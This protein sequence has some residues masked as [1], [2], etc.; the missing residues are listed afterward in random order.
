[1][2]GCNKVPKK[3]TSTPLYRE[4]IH[5]YEI[6]APHSEK[7][8]AV[9]FLFQ[10]ISAKYSNFN[11]GETEALNLLADSLKNAG[12][13][14]TLD[15]IKNK[16]K[17]LKPE[18]RNDA[19]LLDYESLGSKQLIEHIDITYSNW[20]KLAKITGASFKDYCEYILPY[21]VLNEPV[22]E[23]LTKELSSAYES[24]V[25][26]L[27]E[28]NAVFEIVNHIV[29]SDTMVLVP[30]LKDNLTSLMSVG[31]A[32]F[33]KI[34]PGCDNATMYKVM[35]L[36]SVGI[37]ATYDYLPQWGNHHHSGH[38]WV[39]V[40]WQKK[41]YGFESFKGVCIMNQYRSLS[42]P[43]V[44][45]KSYSTSSGND[46]D[47]TENYQQVSKIKVKVP[48]QF[49]F[50]KPAIAV[51]N[52]FEGFRVIDTGKRN[53]QGFVYDNLGRKSVLF[54][55]TV[56]HEQFAPI[57][58]PVYIDSSGVAKYLIPDYDSLISV[59]LYRK[60][61]LAMGMDD[62]DRK[63]GW[64]RTLSG[65]WVEGSSNDFVTTDTL[66]YIDSFCS[67]KEEYF[68]LKNDV[69]YTAVRYQCSRGTNLASV[70]FLDRNSS[71]LKGKLI[72]NLWL[73]KD[74]NKLFND[75]L[76]DWLWMVDNVTGFEHAYVGFRFDQPTH[77]TRVAL[78]S[79]N[80]GNQ[81]VAGEIYELMVWNMGWK[82]LGVKTATGQFLEYSKIPS[83]G[84]YW[85]KNLSN[86]TEELPFMIVENGEQFWPG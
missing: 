76:L 15:E 59:K 80:D 2:S 61:P 23:L 74:P 42:I 26:G 6:V 22:T 51:F 29:S 77:I 65:S 12:N 45:R 79:R 37:P 30:T 47:V 58:A 55:G 10:H 67:Y 40:K 33:F 16:L 5:H 56:E 20:Q 71:I 85:L 38:S 70:K 9:L 39:A 69:P 72:H 75:D 4:V 60:C 83:G 7:K 46:A 24:F 43:K 50:K 18:S 54:T 78:L 19:V 1:M 62:P 3:I 64:S 57:N 82:S 25:N 35:V 17:N 84:F 8:Q 11:K 52:K 44:F 32:R 36:R 34:V 81:I 31:H 73:D 14:L 21:R 66:I 41:W 49:I 68:E 63:L 28:T 53:V 48:F 27:N 86:G 13:T